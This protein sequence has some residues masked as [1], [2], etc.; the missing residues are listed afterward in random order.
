MRLL[1]TLLSTIMSSAVVLYL[2]AMMARVSP[3]STLQQTSNKNQKE[4]KREL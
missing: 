1:L 4:A 2:A 3:V